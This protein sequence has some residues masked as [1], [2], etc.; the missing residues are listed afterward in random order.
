MGRKTPRKN[1]P[2]ATQSNQSMYVGIFLLIVL[3]STFL[4]LQLTSGRMEKAISYS[5][6]LG[7]VTNGYIM[8]V[9]IE[10]QIIRGDFKEQLEGRYTGF[11][12]ILP[13][14]DNELLPLLKQSQVEIIGEKVKDQ[15]G[16]SL[17]W[18]TVGGLL[19]LAF[20]FFLMRG[21]QGGDSSK[22]FTFAKSRARLHRENT[23]K[24]RFTDVAGCEEAKQDL[25]EVVEFLKRPQKFNA[26]GARIPKGVLLVGSPGTGKTLLAKAVAGEAGVP[27][28]SV[29]GSEFVEMFVGVGAARVRDLFSEARKHAPCIV[30]ID[31]LDAVGRSR[32]T[33][34]GGSHD[35]R[36]QT[37]NQILVEMDGFDSSEGLIILAATNRPDIL[38]PALLRPGRF[39]R[40]VVVD[41]PDIKAREAILK[42]H[43]RKV[44]LASDVDLSVIARGTPG[45]TGADLENLVNEAALNAARNNRKKV[46]MED[47]E[48]AKDKVSLGPERRSLVLSEEDKW[49]TAYHEAGHAIL[50]HILP[51]TD[52]IHKVTIIPRGQALGITYHL[53]E[54]EKRSIVKEE[55]LQNIIMAMG[56][57]AAEELKFGKDYI[58]SGASSDIDHV[59]RFVRTMVCEW[60]MSDVLGPVRY[61]ETEGPVFLGKDL[62]TRKNFSE[63]VHELID[64][65]VQKIITTC[66]EEALKLLKKHE[67]KLD[68]LAKTLIEKEVLNGDDIKQLLGE[69][70]KKHF[71]RL[72]FIKKELSES[73]SQA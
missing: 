66:Y 38:D 25:Q 10:G 55:A 52:P 50:G 26:I 4:L 28:F 37:L 54:V 61:G 70:S 21:V 24:V 67:E 57:R 46:T 49:M 41:K 9:K 48:F 36:E 31:E 30:F 1:N 23:N 72:E 68:L 58:S 13:L 35:E 19:L 11:V 17:T 33:G 56:G 73:T 15:S 6:F 64:E 22:A 63:R 34:L 43:T 53:P 51:L 7:Y 29:S 45:F 59:T 3:V 27:F 8:S 39:D 14:M 44:P 69:V 12:T 16:W 62:M 42:I 32:G 40:Q 65:E 60:G 18:M 47:L 5:Q 2:F 20:I 71:P